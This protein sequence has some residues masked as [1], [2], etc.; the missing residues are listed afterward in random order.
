M[1]ESEPDVILRMTP[2][3]RRKLL[4]AE[5]H[6]RSWGHDYIG[7]EHV[8][9]AFL[10]DAEGLA[11]SLLA[12]QGLA[13]RLRPMLLSVMEQATPRRPVPEEPI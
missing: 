8:L 10:D 9:L 13:A 6:A 4:A 2:R 12:Q 7:T 3:M 11:G 5:R 1:A